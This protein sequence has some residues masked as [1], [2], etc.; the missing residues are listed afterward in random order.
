MPEPDSATEHVAERVRA[1]RKA[2][3][4]T[5]AQLADAMNT[6]GIVWNRSTVVKLEDKRRESVTV[7][8][9]EALSTVLR[10]PITSFLESACDHCLGNPPP[11][12]TCNQCRQE[13]QEDAS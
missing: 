10:V 6:L 12:Y 9:L 1:L 7:A 2:S 13:G 3:G 11:G 8:E 4:I 5:G